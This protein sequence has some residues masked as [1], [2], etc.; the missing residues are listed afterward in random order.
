M[1]H[2]SLNT[3]LSSY[4]FCNQGIVAEVQTCKNAHTKTGTFMQKY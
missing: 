2:K 4:Y 3:S 1:F